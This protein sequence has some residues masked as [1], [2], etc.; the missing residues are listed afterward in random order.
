MA[1]ILIVDDDPNFRALL[2]AS[3]VDMGHEVVTA[4][5]GAAGLE[6]AKANPPHI[7]ISD[8]MMPEMDGVEFNTLLQMDSRTE[9]IPVLMLTGDVDKHMEVST[10][11]VSTLNFEFIIGK[12][13]PLE[14]IM[15]VVKDMLA[16]YYQL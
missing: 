14:R 1:L 4:E 2:E 9:A 15:G 16:K 8:I 7:I 13:A 11:Y 10:N 3:L 6:M 5:N 12:T